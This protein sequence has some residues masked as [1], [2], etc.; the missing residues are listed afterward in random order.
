MTAAGTKRKNETRNW[1][2]CRRDLPRD[3]EIGRKRLV[4]RGIISES[5]RAAATNRDRTEDSPRESATARR[6]LS[7]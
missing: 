5:A 1:A 6:V 2:T 4:G 3:R 7:E